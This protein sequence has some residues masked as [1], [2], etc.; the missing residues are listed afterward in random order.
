ML[1]TFTYELDESDTIVNVSSNWAE[2]A[3][4]N[5]V[6]NERQK[7]VGANIWDFI[8]DLET[9]HLYKLLY[10][11]AR[12]GLT[13]PPIPFRCDSPTKK[14]FL[15][16]NIQK[17]RGDHLL[18]KSTI[19]KEEERIPVKLL[20]VEAGRSSEL[21]KMCSM[22]KKVETSKGEWEEVEQYVIK[23]KYFE[24]ARIPNLSHGLCKNCYDIAKSDFKKE[25]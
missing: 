2:F 18:I 20:D 23:Q 5:G 21:V 19:I 4:D 25:K 15:E 3:T 11:K 22:C 6:E 1:D 24:K 7:F 10:R 8:Q 14:R 12:K 9:Q 16:L 13:I 17:I